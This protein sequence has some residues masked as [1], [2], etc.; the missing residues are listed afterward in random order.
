[1]DKQESLCCCF[2]LWIRLAL[3]SVGTIVGPRTLQALPSAFSPGTLWALH[4]SWK[5]TIRDR[6]NGSF[7]LPSQGRQGPWIGTHVSNFISFVSCKPLL[8]LL[9]H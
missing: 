3:G 2:R 8:V 1:M 4:P 7:H 6:C 5:E 9:S